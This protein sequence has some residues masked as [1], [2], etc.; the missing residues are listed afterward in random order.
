MK[1]FAK[2]TAFVATY[3]ALGAVAR[4]VHDRYLDLQNAKEE[5]MP[6]TQAE[7]DAWIGEMHK[8]IDDVLEETENVERHPRYW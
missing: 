1:K 8:I 7:L 4:I 3:L 5:A 6:I 2:Y